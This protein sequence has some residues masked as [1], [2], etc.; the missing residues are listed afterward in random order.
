MADASNIRKLCFRCGVDVAGKPRTKDS[1]GHYYCAACDA[2]VRAAHARTA[3]RTSA[4]GDSS[5]GRADDRG[6]EP[7]DLL[8]LAHGDVASQGAPDDGATIPRADDTFPADELAALAA[9]ERSAQGMP[10]PTVEVIEAESDAPRGRG[11]G[12]Q[13][14]SCAACGRVMSKN[15]VICVACGYN[16]ETGR[17]IGTGKVPGA[18]KTCIKCGYDMTGAPS[19]R[20]PE[21][22]TVNAK[23]GRRDHDREYSK[24]VARATYTKPLIQM[25][26]ALPV[27]F[28]L[29]WHQGGLAMAVV[30]LF[31]FGVSLPV[32]VVAFFLVCLVMTGFDEPL[33]VAGLK[34]AGI[35]AIAD[36][37]GMVFN[38]IP[39][40][41]IHWAVPLAI[42]IGMLMEEF[43][44]DLS[45]AIGLAVLTF[46][47]KMGA[48]VG[49]YYLAQ[50]LGWI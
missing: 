10:I 21:C 5:D 6:D 45:E 8:G 4:S 3:G 12:R 13:P 23:R 22:G 41:M 17:N 48:F 14:R 50:H 47:F 33:H 19:I 20:C 18:G 15:S 2:A 27:A 28:L 32:G 26:I 25:A 31:Q 9:A 24:Q 42:Y 16:T 40:P 43:E 7:A 38:Y 34:L 1:R 36:A 11:F 44:L 35:F 49:M 46:L 29:A 30:Y 39:F 37:I